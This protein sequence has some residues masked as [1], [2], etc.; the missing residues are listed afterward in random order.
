VL[1]KIHR[2]GIGHLSPNGGRLVTSGPIERPPAPAGAIAIVPRPVWLFRQT[3]RQPGS[4]FPM[5]MIRS[6]MLTFLVRSAGRSCN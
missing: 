3:R 5:S 1:A 6:P 4:P 2:L